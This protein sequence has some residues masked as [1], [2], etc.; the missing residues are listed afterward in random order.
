MRNVI[1]IYHIMYIKVLSWVKDS[2]PKKPHKYSAD[3]CSDTFGFSF[4]FF[5][6]ARALLQTASSLAPHM[7]EPHFNF[8][9]ISDKV[10]S[11]YSNLVFKKIIQ[12]N[13]GILTITS[14][15]KWFFKHNYYKHICLPLRDRVINFKER[16]H[17]ILPKLNTIMDCRRIILRSKIWHLVI[18]NILIKELLG[19]GRIQ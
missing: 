16:Y 5:T 17:R 18:K 13:K 6:Q 4:L 7:Y 19:L 12:I 10:F 1:C 3:I 2:L 14:E 11:F 8:A 15:K 9:T